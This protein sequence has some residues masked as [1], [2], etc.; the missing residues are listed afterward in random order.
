MSYWQLKKAFLNIKGPLPL[1]KSG[2]L[3]LTMS[4]I[5]G[6]PLLTPWGPIAAYFR[7]VFTPTLRLWYRYLLKET[8]YWQ[9]VNNFWTMTA[10]LHS[11]KI[12]QLRP[13]NGWDYMAN[14]HLLW[15]QWSTI[16]WTA[17]CCYTSSLLQSFS[18]N[19]I[20]RALV[21]DSTTDFAPW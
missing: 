8:S 5:L 2:E 13:T 9:T 15:A 3:W 6:F 7:V 11:P 17:T 14:V 16:R 4:K 18:D 10:V 20:Y 12:W 19:I 21:L 1:P